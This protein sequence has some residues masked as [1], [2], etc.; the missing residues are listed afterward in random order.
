MQEEREDREQPARNLKEWQAG[1]TSLIIP[2]S[3][4]FLSGRR[5]RGLS[6]FAGVI[7]MAALVLWWQVPSLLLPVAAIWLWNAVDAFFLASGR[8]IRSS[9]PIVLAG[10]VIYVIGFNA[11]NFRMDRLQGGRQA[12]TPFVRSLVNPE[13]FT[14]ETEDLVGLE[15]IQVPCVDPLPPPDRNPTSEPDVILSVPC[16]SVGD[17]IIIRGEGYFPELEG[18][19]RWI[20]PIGDISR[21]LIDGVPVTF[22]TDEEGRFEVEI[23]VPDA[24]PISQRPPEGETQTHAVRAEQHRPFGPPIQTQTL[25]LVIEKIGETIALAFMATVLGVVFA[26]PFSFLA[27]RNLMQAN[28][29]TRGVYYVVRTTLNIVRSIETLMWAIIFAVWVGLGPFAGT[30]ALWLHTVAALGKLYSESIESIDPGPIEALRATGAN[31][32]QTVVYAVLPQIMPAFTSFTLYR[33]DINVRLSTVIGLVSDAGLGFL[34]IQWIR[35]NRLSSMATAIIAIVIVVAGLDFVSGWVRQRIIAGKPLVNFKIPQV[36]TAFRGLTVVG[37]VALFIWSWQ[38]AEIDLEEL[39][40]GAPQ[41]LRIARAFAVPDFF[42]TPQD[43]ISISE[44][45]SVPCD[46]GE[47]EADED[48][49]RSGDVRITLSP[50]CGSAGDPLTITGEGLPPQTDVSVRWQFPDG[51]FLRIQRG[52]CTTDAEGRLHLETTIHPLL[53]QEIDP[54]ELESATELGGV[55]IVWQETAGNIR[56]S[57]SFY[58]VVDLSIVT[59]L[60]ALMATTFGSLFAIPLSFLAARNITGYGHIGSTVYYAFRTL[61]NVTRSVEPLILVLVAAAWVGAGPFAGMLALALNNIPNLGKLFS[62]T[63]EEID[64]GP[65]EALRATGANQLQV[66]VYAIVPQLVPRFLAFIL[67]QWD[68]NIR[69]STVIGFVGGGGIGQQFRIWVGLNQYSA[70]GMATWAIV[71]MVWSMD[72]LS[73]KA[74][75]E[76]V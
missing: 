59:L 30:L 25:E 69:M 18:E 61:F 48:V 70:A 31:G 37:F 46:I 62:E 15:P 13:L 16:A 40:D 76:M 67:Y 14:Y 17:A 3:G 9:I 42:D 12:I 52:C 33:W 50:N 22:V 6:L 60:M 10:L 49:A 11:V 58:R 57:E 8:E 39:V 28:A 73:A 68:I 24:V 35:L 72:Y 29:L 4:Q 66:L 65:V 19:L 53:E 5:N 27:A 26:V 7:A 2:G 36:N 71:A 1:L 21:P 38:V 51:A 54:E 34:V 63:I 56:L 47:A 74:R 45:L 75:E 44:P 43:E 32:P 41:G 23:R 55:S 20:N 64:P